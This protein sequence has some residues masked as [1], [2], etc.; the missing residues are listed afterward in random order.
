[1]AI[2]DD[3][4][5][6]VRAAASI[7]DVVGQHVQL[8]RTGRNWVGLCPFHAEKTPSFNVR[9]ETGRYR[10]FG[11]DKSGDVFTFVQEI[12]HVDF[13]GAVEQ[14]AGRAGIQ[15]TYTTTGQSKE[16]AR[17]KQLVEAMHTAVDWYHERLLTGPDARAARDYLRSR[18]LAGDVARQF[19]LGWAPDEWDALARQAGIPTDLLRDNGLAFMNRRNKLQDSFRARI[20]FPIF[21]ENGEPVALGGRILPGSADPAKYKN[22]SETPIYAKSRTLYGLNW[23][24]ADAVSANQVIVCEGYT[25][26]IGFHRA[27]LPRAVATCGTAFTEEHV[28]HLKRYASRV[29]LAFDADAAGQGAAE[30]FYEWEEKYQVEVRVAGFPGGKDPGEIA[31]E[32]PSGLTKAV[33][34]A[35]PFLGFR[36]E[37]VLG[38][39][40]PDSPE[41]VARLGEAAMAVVNEHPNVNI[42][43]LYAGEVATRVGLPVNDLVSMAERGQRRPSVTVRP[44]QRRPERRQNAEFAV[45]SLLVQDWDSIAP[46]LVESLFSDDVYRRAFL[47]I[48]DAGGDLTA[49]LAAADPESRDVIERAAVVDLSVDP[50][51]EARNLVGAAVRRELN[52]RVRNAD[53]GRI[54][55][56]A[57]ARVRMEELVDPDRAV[58]AMGWLLGWLEERRTEHGE[59]A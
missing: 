19:K 10:C 4:I 9:E 58:S 20:L 55:A 32:D 46:W 51:L 48:A 47:A 23:A 57:E 52:V 11:C 8:R 44:A 34:E 12:E 24:K 36:L 17:R 30:R 25:D 16:R 33:D 56:D 54:R 7:V 1:M 40:R 6:R 39:R 41:G 5:E 14:L 13:A 50:G 3:D 43:K 15:L 37:R 18:G 49:A 31:Q 45:L 28:R 59:G 35:R 42:R 53:S 21:S 26:V 29:V 22:S 38:G 27:G 2:A